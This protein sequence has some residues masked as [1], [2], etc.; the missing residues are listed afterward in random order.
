MVESTVKSKQIAKNTLILYVRMLVLMVVSFYTSRVILEALGIEDFGI[1]SVVGGFISM[2]AM[3]SA[4]LSGA[5]SRYLTF[6]LGRNERE[7]LN[8]VFST[9]IIIQL[10]ISGLILILGETLA[11]WFLNTHMT[12]PSERL[13]SANWVL[14]F[15][16]L[17]F[18]FNLMSIPYNAS[19][20]S[21]EHMS[22]FAYIGIFEGMA[23]LAIALIISYTNGDR[24]IIYSM[25]MCAVAVIIRIAYSI[26]CRKHFEECKFKLIF[27]NKLFK[28]MFGFAGWNFIGVTSG[29]LR[30]QG[31]NMMIN[32]FCGPTVN[33]ARGIA[34]QVNTAITRF[35]SNFITATK[36]QIIK[37]YSVGDMKNCEN[38]VEKSAKFSF[39]LLMLLCLP[40]LLETQYVLTIWLKEIPAH[41]T[42]FVQLTL[43]LSLLESYSHPL[44]ILILSTGNIKKYQIVVGLAQLLSFPL[45]CTLLYL[46]CIP[47]STVICVIAV[48]V[49]CLFLRLWMLYRMI[50]FSSLNFLIRVVARTSII[51]LLSL[52]LSY[53]TVSNMSESF[54][55]LIT[56][57]TT[58]EIFSITIIYFIGLEKSERMFL[59][60]KIACIKNKIFK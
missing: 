13:V 10:I 41:T 36:P 43:M 44:I 7:K 16:L 24:L 8:K 2:F 46:N 34:M 4:S 54:L 9:S 51:F 12:I 55:R 45:A 31:I 48:S 26:Y 53:V 1:Y 3:I 21:H 27:D 5:I 29:V 50:K 58:T 25:L 28:E 60:S 14:Q 15:S 22:A 49:I 59:S 56:T 11:V 47:E 37:L 35:S 57:I 38:L 30:D 19:L 32:I 42:L 17:T 20:I 33:A 39:Y 40:L 18:V 6:Y 52:F 23:N